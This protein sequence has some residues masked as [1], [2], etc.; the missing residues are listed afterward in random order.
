MTDIDCETRCQRSPTILHSKVR[1]T[2]LALAMDTGD[3]FNFT[4]PSGRLWE[5]LEQ[6]V[7]ASQAA[8]LLT[9]EFDVDFESCRSEVTAFLGRLLD[10]DLIVIAKDT[11]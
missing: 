4:G 11:A 9:E 5:L 2:V 6:P 3:C 1:D 7:S 8:R 10:E